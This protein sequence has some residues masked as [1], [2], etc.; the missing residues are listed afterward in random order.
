VFAGVGGGPG[1]SSLR[2]ATKQLDDRLTDRF[3]AQA[4]CH[5]HFGRDAAFLAQ[6]PEQQVLGA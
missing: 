5:Q 1:G 3:D 6:Q 4:S 2:A